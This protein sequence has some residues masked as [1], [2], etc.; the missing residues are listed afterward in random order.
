MHETDQEWRIIEGCFSASS[1]FSDAKKLTSLRNTKNDFEYRLQQSTI[2]ESKID[3]IDGICDRIS[4]EK[5]SFE[6]DS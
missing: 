2:R 1:T 3:E 4:L 6:K 5:N